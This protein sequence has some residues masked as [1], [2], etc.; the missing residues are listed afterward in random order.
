MA[1]IEVSPDILTMGLTL[2]F[3]GEVGLSFTEDTFFLRICSTKKEMKE[4]VR[5]LG[6]DYAVFLFIWMVESLRFIWLFIDFVINPSPR[7]HLC[8][9]SA[10]LFFVV[11]SF[12]SW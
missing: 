4:M 9:C 6:R 12:T 3:L 8:F 11:H 5:S 1:G 7:G 2:Y 10:F